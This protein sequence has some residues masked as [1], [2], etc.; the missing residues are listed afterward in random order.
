MNNNK[1]SLP[2]S[3][4][5]LVI[6]NG[7][8]GAT[9]SALLGRYGVATL[10]VD[11]AHDILLMPRAI[12][13]DNEAL[14]ILQLAGLDEGSFE[15]VVIPQVK[16]HCPL[17]GQFG[18]AN[19][20]GRLDGHP[21]LVTFYQPDLEQAMRQQAS[22]F[23]NVRFEGGLTLLDLSQDAD[24]VVA[25]LEDESGVVHSVRAQYLV[26]ADGASSKV[27]GLI[28][29]DFGGKSFSE[30]WLIVDAASR[31]GQAID[32]VEFLCD[33]RRPTPH[34]PAPGGRER[35]EFMLQRGECRSEMES[36]ERISK[37]LERWIPANELQVERKA[38]YRFHARCCD[39]FQSGRIFLVGDA[40]HI[41]PPFVGQGLVAGLRD[42]ANLA[43]K[44]SWVLQGRA[45]NAIL[46]TYD[47]ERRPHAQEMIA[48]AKLMGRLVM[49]TNALAAVAIH[50]FMRAL[51][52]IPPARRHLEELEIKPK[53]R[54]KRGLFTP[55]R[56]RK[57]PAN[58]ALFPQGWVRYQGRVCLS[59]DLLGDG[60]QLVGLGT[61]PRSW[62]DFHQQQQWEA[63]GGS[64]LQVGLNRSATTGE[65]V[66]ELDGS[67]LGAWTVPT[68]AV[69]RPDRIIMHQMPAD[70]AGDL[71]ERCKALLRA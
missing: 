17:I 26:G 42:A 6:G 50:G 55:D 8:V 49:P 58:G 27:R 16:M 28:G 41:T 46:A 67:L 19:T 52:L 48:L 64:F 23:T 4:D 59:D 56:R 29:Q 33:H 3:V 34:M 62:L 68:L 47:Q 2:P 70:R 45:S 18:Q 25:S 61:N 57:G 32:H 35:W 31:H 36:D 10:V 13:L 15:T 71:L 9:L 53:N 69:V 44:L 24:G 1:K 65:F 20:S 22:S 11:K 60:L 12:A 63:M 7:P 21:K 43:W 38:V 40:A 30:D 39:S 66:E 37:L 54:F 51:R 14:R 5:I